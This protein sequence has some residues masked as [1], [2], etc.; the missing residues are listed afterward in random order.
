MVIMAGEG[1]RSAKKCVLYDARSPVNC[2]E[3]LKGLLMYI[4]VAPFSD[5]ITGLSEL[6][7][8]VRKHATTKMKIKD[9]RG[10][11]PFFKYFMSSPS[12]GCQDDGLAK[13]APLHTF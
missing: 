9:T 5:T 2:A 12:L 4:H 13:F 6:F 8:M 10:S 3:T 7:V 11:I 1:T